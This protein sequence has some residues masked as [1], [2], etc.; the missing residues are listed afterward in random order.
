[1]DEEKEEMSF[2][3][4]FFNF[5]SS[6]WKTIL[7]FIV[8]FIFLRLFTIVKYKMST[9]EISVPLK[10]IKNKYKLSI[11]ERR[12][13]RLRLYIDIVNTLS[14]TVPIYLVLFTSSKVN[15]ILVYGISLLI[16]IIVLIGGY[17]LIGIIE[18]RK[19]EK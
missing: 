1:M 11:R 17:N 4:K 15:R 14:I 9:D 13:K 2:G 5:L 16:F 19:E 3:D 8:I 6:N 12:S 10:Y 7:A 18:K